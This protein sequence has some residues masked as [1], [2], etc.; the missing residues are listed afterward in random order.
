MKI[1]F[2]ACV[3]TKNFKH[4]K[5]KFISHASSHSHDLSEYII[6]PPKLLS[7]YVT[8]CVKHGQCIP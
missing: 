1:S 3:K 7:S 5:D 8:D 6:P 2:K 4:V